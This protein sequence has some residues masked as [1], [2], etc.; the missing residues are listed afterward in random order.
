MVS[1]ARIMNYNAQTSVECLCNTYIIK[2]LFH[3][4]NCVIFCEVCSLPTPSTGDWSFRNTN[5]TCNHQNFIEL[6]SSFRIQSG[7]PAD[8]ENQE[9]VVNVILPKTAI[10]VTV[11]LND[12]SSTCSYHLIVQQLKCDDRCNQVRHQCKTSSINSWHSV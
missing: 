11:S 4:Q 7:L 2:Y 9:C 5:G 8:T 12:S 6:S 10:G 3:I 1:I